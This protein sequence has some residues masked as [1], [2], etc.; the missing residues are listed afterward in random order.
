[1]LNIAGETKDKLGGTAVADTALAMIPFLIKGKYN[2]SK[3]ESKLKLSPTPTYKG[4]KI[5]L[6]KLQVTGGNAVDGEIK[7]K[8]MGMKGKATIPQ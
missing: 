5:S 3:D 4:A 8:I 2:D 1:V 7:Y 6:K